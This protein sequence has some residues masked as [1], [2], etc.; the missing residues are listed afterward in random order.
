M[1]ENKNVIPGN[2]VSAIKE[3]L[4]AEG[5]SY[6]F[7]EEGIYSG[8]D[9]VEKIVT[10]IEASKIF[11]FVSTVNS[12]ISPWTSKE[13]ASAAELKKI[14]IPLRIDD[15]PY[16]KKVLFRIADLSYIQYYINPEKALDELVTSIKA[17]LE[18]LQLE[19]KRRQEAAERK[20]E[21]ER[22]RREEE[23]RMKREEAAR[24]QKGARTA[25]YRH[26]SKM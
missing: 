10:N 9:F 13:I 17:Y 20:R 15:S 1:D 8:D 22:R 24:I 19:A 2:V 12:N 23:E 21:E 7:D 4:T 26:R 18:Q 14:I 16:N 25:Y 11:L 6:W 3:R 5:I